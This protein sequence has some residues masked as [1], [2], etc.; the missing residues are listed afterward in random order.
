MTGGLLDFPELTLEFVYRGQ[1]LDGWH[2]LVGIGR[3]RR[4]VLLVRA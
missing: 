4:R 3:L 2:V 1:L